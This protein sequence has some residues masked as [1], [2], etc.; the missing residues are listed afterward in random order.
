MMACLRPRS[1]MGHKLFRYRL[2][3][4][5]PSRRRSAAGSCYGR[6]GVPTILRGAVAGC[7]PS[8]NPF[9]TPANDRRTVLAEMIVDG[10]AMSDTHFESS[11]KMVKCVDPWNATRVQF[12]PEV[13]RR[14]V[15]RV[16]GFSRQ[17]AVAQQRRVSH[18]GNPNRECFVAG[19][20]RI[21]TLRHESL[22]LFPSKCSCPLVLQGDSVAMR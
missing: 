22:P 1:S 8:S 10:G 20:G 12:R 11:K 21:G 15:A 14:E 2:I 17:E 9:L 19:R 5:A 13:V 3:L 16:A 7:G 6:P 18:R 4:G